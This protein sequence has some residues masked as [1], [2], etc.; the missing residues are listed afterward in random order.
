[1]STC[2]G[3]IEAA[4]DYGCGAATL[5]QFNADGSLTLD[6][7]LGGWRVTI[8]EGI[9]K[10]IQFKEENKC[11]GNTNTDAA[12]LPRRGRGPFQGLICLRASWSKL[13]PICGEGLTARKRED[14]QYVKQKI[15]TPANNTGVHSD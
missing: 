4:I 14:L 1:M 15:E 9:L 10:I 6:M 12:P 13:C 11:H 8:F 2:L 7:R 3:S 5:G